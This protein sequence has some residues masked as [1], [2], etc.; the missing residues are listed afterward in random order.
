MAEEFWFHLSGWVWLKKP[1]TK[2]SQKP[3]Y[4]K[5]AV[6][7]LCTKCEARLTVSPGQQSPAC[8]DMELSP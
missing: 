7:P 6:L 1:S 4:S 2:T 8:R 5:L 3:I